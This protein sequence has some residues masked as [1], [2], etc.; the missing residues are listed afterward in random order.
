VFRAVPGRVLIARSGGE[1]MTIAGRAS[2]AWTALDTPATTREVWQR[3]DDALPE[4][5]VS[6]VDV[7]EAMD[8]LVD[9]GVVEQCP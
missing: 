6:I 9:A 2:V 4:V 3:V 1:K 7:A 5:G 8:V